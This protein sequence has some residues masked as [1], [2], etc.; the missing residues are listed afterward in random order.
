MTPE[1]KPQV[2]A[3]PA[4][5]GGVHRSATHTFTKPSCDRVE[6]VAGLGVVGDAHFGACVRHRGR[7]RLDPDQP[8]LRQVHLLA[9]ELLDD[10]AAV[11]FD[12]APGQLGENVTTRNLDLYALPVGTTLRL[13]SDAL[14]AL[15][16]L[17]N[18]CRQI[19]RFAPGLLDE[20]LGRAGGGQVR[21]AGVMAVVVQSGV[22]AAGDVI[23]AGVP[24]GPHRR[25]ERV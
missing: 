18:P 12:V 4:L 23:V 16:G 9:G 8:N 13:G 1:R 11:G 25:L 3:V 17:R 19:D 6:L 15:T 14:V 24:P 10:L 22:V 20:V 2:P 5:V 7:V 21:G